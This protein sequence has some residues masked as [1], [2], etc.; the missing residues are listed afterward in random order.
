MVNL[1]SNEARKVI[2]E[3]LPHGCPNCGGISWD[4]HYVFLPLYAPAEDSEG[5][6]VN[7]RLSCDNCGFV[8]LFSAEK[9]GFQ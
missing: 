6:I 4:A 7:V 8:S 3:K 1:L 2:T 9:L 5:G